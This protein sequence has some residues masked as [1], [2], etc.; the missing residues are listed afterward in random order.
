MFKILLTGPPRVGKSTI[1]DKVLKAI[2]GPKYGVI[3]YEIREDGERVGFRSV[4][5]SDSDSSK[6]FG[7][8][9]LVESDIMVSKY[10]VNLPAIDGF[11]SDQVR[12]GLSDLE[13]VIIIDEV[14]RMQSYSEIFLQTIR[15][16]LSDR[17]A[18]VLGTI[19]QAPD[20]WSLEFKEDPNV[21]IVEVTEENREEMA[22]SLSGL[23][24]VVEQIR[25]CN[26]AQQE[27]ICSLIRSYLENGQSTPLRKLVNNAL[28]YLLNDRIELLSDDSY[29]VT[30]NHGEYPVSIENGK[31]SC[32][33]NLFNGREGYDPDE[34][35]HIQSVRLYQLRES[36]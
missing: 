28:E 1:V 6:I 8:K 36:S 12:A 33:C 34:C 20:P 3:S 15:D 23:Y 9:N 5:L 7:H 4:S 2:A 11:V 35:S 25:K 22:A 14:G 29:Q 16:V 32:T 26:A 27:H 13:G 31:F 21:T 19:V 17:D 30:G 18:C 24:S 10:K